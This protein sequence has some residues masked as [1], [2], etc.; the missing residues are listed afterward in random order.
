MASGAGHWVG[1][2]FHQ[3]GAGV[4]KKPDPPSDRGRDG[5]DPAGECAADGRDRKTAAG[6]RGISGG[7][8]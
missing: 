6:D 7:G 5:G 1:G 3:S 2:G 8:T 4:Y